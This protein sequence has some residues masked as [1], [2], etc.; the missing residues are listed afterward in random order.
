MEKVFE[1]IK[2]RCWTCHIYKRQEEIM[3]DS[4][5]G[6]IFNSMYKLQD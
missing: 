1:E 6:K 2:K 3:T 4:V 5:G